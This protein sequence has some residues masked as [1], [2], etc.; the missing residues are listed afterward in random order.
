MNKNRTTY[1]DNIINM[2]IFP[3][4]NEPVP[5]NIFYRNGEEFWIINEKE[6]KVPIWYIFH[7]SI[8]SKS[9]E[10]NKPEML[11]TCIIDEN[12]LASIYFSD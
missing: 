12:T 3:N 11:R 10:L 1:G 8:F 6:F 9:L 7:P 5:I 4:V 2:E